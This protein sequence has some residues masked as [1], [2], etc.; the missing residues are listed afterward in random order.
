[1]A[2]N[3]DPLWQT[4]EITIAEGDAIRDAN[5]TLI[6]EQDRGPVYQTAAAADDNYGLGAITSVS[7]THLTLPTIRSV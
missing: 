5:I 7:Y 2:A 6:L 4:P 3:A 1:M